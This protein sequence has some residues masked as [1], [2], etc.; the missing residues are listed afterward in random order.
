MT[1]ATRRAA[2]LDRLGRDGFV[3]VAQL[4]AQ[5]GC[6]PATVRRDLDQLERG[7]FLVRTRGGA[8]SDSSGE[9]PI[10]SKAASMAVEKQ[11]I[12]AAAAAMVEDGQAVGL[13]GGTTTQQVAR[14]LSARRG[15]TVV[16][17]AINV[18]IE[19]VDADIR[20]VVVGGELRGRSW[21]LVGPLSEPVASQ[22]HLDVFFA[23]VDG[24]SASG[25]LT[26]HNPLEARIDRVL[27]DRAQRIV[28][29]C[30]HTKLGRATFAQIAPL[31]I[32][33]EVVTDSGADPA[34]VRELERAG[35]RVVVAE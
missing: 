17:N 21:E 4:E 1:T 35:V 16:T 31:E 27:I 5:L 11:Q 28:V 24:L 19:L 14:A 7:G 29:V 26:T 30:D 22:L 6:S 23:G 33:H 2:I 9:L 34:Q 13:T 32:V 18:A 12:A 15:L 8:I 10:R 20:T 3:E 25:G